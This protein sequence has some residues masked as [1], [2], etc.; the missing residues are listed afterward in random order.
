M[1]NFIQISMIRKMPKPNRRKTEIERLA[2]KKD[3]VKMMMAAK[4][5]KKEKRKKKKR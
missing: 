5:K 4:A 2:G 1:F 3:I